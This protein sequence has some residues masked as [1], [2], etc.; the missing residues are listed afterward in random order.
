MITLLI[1][2]FILLALGVPV[3]FAIG[4]SAFSYFVIFNP[5]LIQILPQRMYAGID[6]YAMIALPLFIFMG[7][8]MNASTITKQLIDF[9]LIF[10]GRLKGGLLYVDVAASLIFGG[11]SGSSTSDVA[12]IGQ[13]LIPEQ[14]RR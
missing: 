13:I 9:A 3:A 6:S 8:V 10:V 5:S 1:S 4:L 2:L 14:Q 12:S 7:Q 11:I